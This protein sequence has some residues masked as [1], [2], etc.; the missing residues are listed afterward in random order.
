VS[1]VQELFGVQLRLRRLFEE[2]TVAGMVSD[3]LSDLE[4]R[5]TIEATAEVIQQV[6]EFS[7]DEVEELLEER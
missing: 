4:N 5:Q 3:L 1:Q 2:P 6:N 7:E